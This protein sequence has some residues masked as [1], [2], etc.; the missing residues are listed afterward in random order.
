MGSECMQSGDRE[1]MWDKSSDVLSMLRRIAGAPLTD[2]R[3]EATAI[4]LL[5]PIT[6]SF[7]FWNGFPIIFYDTGAYLL[8]GLG[9]VFLAERSPVYSLLLDYAG[10]RESLW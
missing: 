4:L 5:V 2:A 1:I 8:E 3:A 7:A 9:R 6:L 10:A